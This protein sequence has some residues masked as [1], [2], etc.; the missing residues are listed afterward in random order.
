MPNTDVAR[1]QEWTK[2]EK[3]GAEGERASP[4]GQ[5]L[6]GAERSGM[7]SFRYLKMQLRIKIFKMLKWAFLERNVGETERSIQKFTCSQVT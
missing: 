1:E 5:Y 4:G 2:R 6:L 3:S 7:K